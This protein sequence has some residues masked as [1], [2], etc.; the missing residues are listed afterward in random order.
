MDAKSIVKQVLKD[1]SISQTQLASLLGYTAASG[2]TNRLC[3]SSKDMS[4]ALFAD[5]LSAIG[6]EVVVQPKTQGKRKDGAMVL[7]PSGLPDG[8][9]KKRKKEGEENA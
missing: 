5:M 7:E 6:Y 9:G 4:C 2:V 8:R 3:T 1:K